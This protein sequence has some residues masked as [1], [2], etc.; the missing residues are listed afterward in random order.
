MPENAMHD[1]L[2]A[3]FHRRAQADSHEAWLR[4]LPPDQ[5]PRIE[6]E[7]EALYTHLQ[8][9]IT[10]YASTHE[11]LSKGLL[12]YALKLLLYA[13]YDGAADHI[14]QQVLDRCLSDL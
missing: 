1:G 7:V 13:Y 2:I 14:R 4:R 8:A 11:P 10:A 12:L 9:A 5:L 3:W 6:H